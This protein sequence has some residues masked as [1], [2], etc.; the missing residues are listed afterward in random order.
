M[1]KFATTQ[2][3]F[4]LLDLSN[5]SIPKENNKTGFNKKALSM[6]EQTKLLK[7]YKTMKT[8]YYLIVLFGLK[9]GLRIGEIM[10]L[11][12]NDIDFEKYTLEVNKQWKINKE[13]GSYSFGNLNSKNSYRTIPLSKS[14]ILELK[15][16]KRTAPIDTFYRII[17]NSN[18]RN[19]TININKHLKRN[20]SVTPHELR[21]TYATNL[22]SNGIDFKTAAK[23]LG[24]EVEQTMKVYSHVTD[25]MLQAASNVIEQLS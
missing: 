15:E 12:W 8:D 1:L 9:A 16:I 18:T 21:H 7:H 20:A 24:H 10:G 11:T 13:T 5:I 2:Y 6:Q 19:I 4:P 25:D 22:I 14:T 3:N 17:T 23:L